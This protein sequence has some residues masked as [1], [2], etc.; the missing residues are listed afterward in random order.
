M[1]YTLFFLVMTPLIASGLQQTT[2]LGQTVGG[3]TMASG[4]LAHGMTASEAQMLAASNITWVSCDVTF[5]PSDIS[6]WQTVYSLA[7]QYHL[8][9]MGI[10]DQH[11]M[12]YSNTFTLTD[13]S[14]AVNQAVAS[15]GSLVKTWQV[16]NEPNYNDSA[17][18]YY[19][20]TPQTYVSMLQVAYNDI[21]AVAPSDTVIGLGG[22]PLYTA[23]NPTLNNTYAM[24]AYTWTQQI[25]QLGGMAYCDAIAVHA[26][27]YGAYNPYAQLLFTSNL[28]QYSQLCSKPIWL[29]EVGQE[30]FSTNWTATQAQQSTFLS[31]SYSLFQG[32]GVKAY[33][34]YELCDNYTAIPNS[35]FGLFDNNGNQKTAFDTYVAAVNGLT[36]PTAAPTATPTQN[37]ATNPT[38]SPS[39]LPSPSQSQTTQP[40]STPAHSDTANS[41]PE[42]NYAAALFAMLAISIAV[43]MSTYLKK[44]R[45]E[46]TIS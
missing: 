43:A 36:S 16:W 7:Q 30:S 1:S 13:W 34:W 42:E 18:G 44:R 31:Q 22:M 3:Y 39:R 17:L 29:T 24:Q 26:Y 23:N 8:S 12:N 6:N 10:L 25:V 15:F 21:K 32:L 41:V 38:S 35:N 37:P 45:L 28:Q 2:S 11:L 14:N 19:N 9:V 27:P 46:K 20:G 5:N 40:T 33:M 4:V